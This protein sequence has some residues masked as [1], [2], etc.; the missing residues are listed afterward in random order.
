MAQDIDTIKLF[1]SIFNPLFGV[2]GIVVSNWASNNMKKRFRSIQTSDCIIFSVCFLL[3]SLFIYL[4]LT[5]I[6]INVYLSLV[7]F[8]LTIFSFNLCWLIK[9]KILLD[10]VEPNLRSTANSLRL[11]AAHSIGDDASPYWTGLIADY[12]LDERLSSTITGQLYCT[13]VSLYPLVFGTFIAASL[14]LFT[15]LTFT[16]DKKK[17]TE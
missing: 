17:S 10:I 14:A 5:L 1:Y 13:R 6:K 12:C 11:F 2:L 8:M 16:N 4:Y 3:A 7:L 9:G 15:T